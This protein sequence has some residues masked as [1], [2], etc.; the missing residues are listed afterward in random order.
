MPK[1]HPVT[2]EGLH[3][4]QWL[5]GERKIDSV[6][7]YGEVAFS[8]EEIVE[9]LP[10][11]LLYNADYHQFS[12]FKGLKQ[13]PGKIKDTSLYILMKSDDLSQKLMLI[14]KKDEIQCFKCLDP[15]ETFLNYLTRSD[16]GL[17][18]ITY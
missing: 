18:S 11:S 2:S 3:F 13:P 15:V 9:D 5:Q 6:V 14:V 7:L 10:T 16:S 12:I 1:E 8:V 17:L 4:Q